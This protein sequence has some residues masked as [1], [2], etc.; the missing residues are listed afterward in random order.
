MHGWRREEEAL[1]QQPYGDI[2][3]L[4]EGSL[5]IQNLLDQGPVR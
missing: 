3:V 4:R 2:D 1:M 5:L